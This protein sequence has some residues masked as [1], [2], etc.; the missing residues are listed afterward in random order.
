MKRLISNIYLYDLNGEGFAG[1]ALSLSSLGQKLG[2]HGDGSLHL[3]VA[4]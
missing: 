4:Q 1:Q 3:H 2:L